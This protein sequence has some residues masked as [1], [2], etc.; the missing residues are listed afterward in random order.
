MQADPGTAY[1]FGSFELYPSERRLL[2][3]GAQVALGARAFDLLL[4]LVERPGELL[5]K[6]S[7]L[8]RVWRG[9]VVEENNLQ[10]QVS[11]LRR[12]LGAG[13]IETVPGCGYRFNAQVTLSSRPAG[14]GARR[15]ELPL[16]LTSFIGREREMRDVESLLKASRL[17]TLTGS[18]GAG[19]TRLSLEIGARV[20]EDYADGVA[21]VE[22]A[23]LSDPGLV[24][25]AVATALGFTEKDGVSLAQ[26]LV[27]QLKTRELLLIFDNC[28]HVVEASA[29]LAQVLLES[30]AGV[31]ILATSRE[32]LRI[33]GETTFRVPS[34]ALPDAGTPS[35]PQALSQYPAIRLF[36]DRA[37]AARTSF[38]IDPSNADAIADICR[39]LDGI[40]LAIELAAAR[41]R[42]LP[43]HEIARHLDQRF[44]LLTEGSRT[45]LPRHRTLRA[46]I[47]WSYDLLDTTEQTLLTRLAVFAGG[48]TL[49][50]AEQVCIGGCV[51]RYEVLALLASLAD[52]S[53]VQADELDGATRYRFLEMVREYAIDRLRERGEEVRTRERHLAYYVSLAEE[54][55]PEFL[56]AR[57]G[58]W[59]ERF[60]AEHDN[61]RL[62]LA[63]AAKEG[64]DPVSGLR[65]AGAVWRFW[66]MHGYIVEGRRWLVAFLTATKGAGP[67][68][69]HL[70][71]LRGA[72]LTSWGVADYAATRAYCDEGLALAG[73]AGDRAAFGMMLHLD[74]QCLWAQGEAHW[75][76]ARALYEQALAIARETGRPRDIAVSLNGLAGVTL[77]EDGGEHRTRALLEEA[78]SLFMAEGDRHGAAYALT[79]LGRFAQR[80]G[81]YEAAVGLLRQALTIQRDLRDRRGIAVSLAGLAHAAFV[82][83]GAVPAAYIF[84]AAERL[85]EE[86]NHPVWPT[87]WP[88]LEHLLAGCPASATAPAAFDRAWQ[89]GRAMA[90]G[91]AIR[92]AL[93][94]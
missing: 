67:P 20:V 51:D 49:D 2:S 93:A 46:L 34:L 21:F 43:T 14:R 79:G 45:A 56:N 76:Q 44:A 70:K 3:G 19:K 73:A 71:A 23:P 31:R 47:E 29:Q 78:V 85:R 1:L 72:G 18:G 48:F 5:S 87:A 54:G 91:E 27:T 84:G 89:S 10:V 82:L 36:I 66:W 50:A 38:R 81:D 35:S 39:R 9:L 13:V 53:L 8:E 64:S 11:S 26:T 59:L 55:E 74:A 65:L 37:Q 12:V 6:E 77:L 15:Y 58:E 63:W 90:L 17:V 75:P 80:Q 22:L 42:T 62:A 32:P 4:A 52:K 68:S 24:P 30:C 57:Q 25:L 86:I 83:R 16:Q 94:E 69:V 60:E 33:T 28:E 61:V 7:L 40:P 88:S 41:A 92:N